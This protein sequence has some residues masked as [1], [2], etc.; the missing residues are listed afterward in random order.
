MGSKRI[1]N[2]NFK[3]FSDLRYGLIEIKL[4]QLIETKNVSKIFLSTDD[5]KII[6]YAKKLKC[7]KIYIYKRDKKLSSDTVPTDFLVK[8]ALDLIQEGDIL[9]THVTSPFINSKIY[10]LIINSYYKALQNGYDS[11]LTGTSYKNFLWYKKKPFNYDNSSIKWPNTQD[12]ISLS[13]INSGAFIANYN[14]YRRYNDRV[15]K[16]PYIL[17]LDKLTAFD[18]D[19]EEDFQIAELIYD[20]KIR[21]I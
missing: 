21:K 14:I 9:W 20:R 11:L 1:K 12:L 7:S 10:N 13:E 4:K 16:K 5:Y 17:D 8:H 6:N 2:K 18:I 19:W 15:G 3:S